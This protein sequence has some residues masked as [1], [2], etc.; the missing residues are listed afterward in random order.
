MRFAVISDVH[1]NLAAL[2]RVISHVETQ[3]VDAIVNLGDCVSA[4]LWPQETF[5]ELQTLGVIAV[6]GNHDRW[7]GDADGA[8]SSPTVALTRSRLSAAAIDALV[9]L[10]ATKRVTSEIFAV[11]GT[12]TSDVAYL[13]EDAVDDRLRYVTSESLGERLHA[14]DAELVLCGHSHV[15]H[16]AW[17]PGARLVLNPGA[18]GAPRYAGNALPHA[19]EAGSPHARYAVVTRTSARWSAELFALD[20]DWALVMR[21]AQQL[22][23]PEW[24]AAFAK[25]F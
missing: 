25:G 7:L 10:P 1:G 19:N 8:Q 23:Y 20:Y 5:D 17:A 9:S 3:G 18:V 24:A 2:R 15:Q 13:L 14:V 22:G 12:P 21:R 4:P 11:H 16:C 6:R